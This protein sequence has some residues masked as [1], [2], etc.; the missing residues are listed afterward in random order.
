VDFE[1]QFSYG[2]VDAGDGDATRLTGVAGVDRYENPR[3]GFR[4]DVPRAL[5]AM[6]PPENGDGMQWRLGRLV[7]MTASGMWNGPDHA[8]PTCAASPNVMGSSRSAASCWATGRRDGYVFWEKSVVKGDVLYSL[9]FQYVD[10]VKEAMDSVVA[11]VTKSWKL[12]APA[13]PEP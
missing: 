9:R 3:F 10:A 12:G 8:P 1:D 2:L 5:T 4:L 6:P 13:K 7:A 11:G